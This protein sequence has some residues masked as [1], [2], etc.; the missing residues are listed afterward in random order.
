MGGDVTCIQPIEDTAIVG[1]ANVNMIQG[2]SMLKNKSPQI[3]RDYM[4]S[5]L[6]YLH[7]ERKIAHVIVERVSSLKSK[8]RKQLATT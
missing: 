8:Q 1:S 4:C 3:A 2:K 6:G 5:Y 7:D